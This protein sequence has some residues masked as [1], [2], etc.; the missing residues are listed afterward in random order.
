MK[1]MTFIILIGI[2]FAS[3]CGMDPRKRERQRK[4]LVNELVKLE[5]DSVRKDL[6]SICEL[7]KVA[8]FDRLVDS[9]KKVRIDDIKRTM[10]SLKK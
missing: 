3:S 10:E 8:N 7:N 6:D 9:L 5:M 2:L 1:K 4:K